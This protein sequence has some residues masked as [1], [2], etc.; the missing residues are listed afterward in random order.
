MLPNDV[1]IHR[2][3]IS[4]GILY[5]LH[6]MQG[7][8]QLKL[9]S[10]FPTVILIRTQQHSQE[11]SFSDLSYELNDPVAEHMAQHSIHGHNRI[12]IEINVAYLREV[13]LLTR[14]HSGRLV[15]GDSNHTAFIGGG[16]F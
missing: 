15:F 3:N 14:F 13:S 12:I 1:N 8:V 11:E 16:Y 4:I 9:E 7:V 6:I 5:K 2:F 10:S